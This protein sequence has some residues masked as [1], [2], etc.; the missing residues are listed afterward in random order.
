MPRR[1]EDVPTIYFGAVIGKSEIGPVNKPIFVK[2]EG[3]LITNFGGP[4]KSGYLGHAVLGYLDNKGFGCYVVNVEEETVEG[5]KAAL[6]TIDSIDGLSFIVAPG[7]IDQEIQEA[8]VAHCRD[9]GDRIAILDTPM[10]LMK[11]E[12]EPDE[13][14]EEQSDLEAG[15][16]SK[17]LGEEVE[18]SVGESEEIEAE[19][20]W[21]PRESERCLYY[22]PWVTV[23]DFK[24][25]YVDVPPSGHVLAHYVRNARRQK[26]AKPEVYCE[27]TGT[28]GL[29][30]KPSEEEI[31]S[32]TSMGIRHLDYISEAPPL[33]GIPEP[34]PEKESEV[35]GEEG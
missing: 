3:Q 28:K 4:V 18:E 8:I 13:M 21:R 34:Q 25:G 24:L 23:W 2:R 27:I 16:E 20:E 30:H 26:T 15:E 22:Y 19:E 32:L 1:S 14:A 9:R 29:E 5:Y 10:E 11:E 31:E 12:E 7:Q 6:K 33:I 35:R 17:E